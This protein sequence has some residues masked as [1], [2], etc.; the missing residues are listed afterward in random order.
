MFGSEF[1]MRLWLKPDRMAKPRHDADRRLSAIQEQNLQAPAGQ[2]GARPAPPTQQFQ[3][4]VQ[5]RG[6]LEQVSRVRG[7][8]R[9]CAARRQLRAR[10]G[11]RAR[12]ARRQGLFL[13]QSRFNGKPNPPPSRST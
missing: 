3:Y 10:Q 2:I 6:Q 11:H 8:H 5:V 1:G 7:H 13:C 12:R 9:A 4:S